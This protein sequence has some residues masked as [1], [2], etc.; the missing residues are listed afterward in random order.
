[1][2]TI[3]FYPDLQIV[4]I[5]SIVLQEYVQKS[6]AQK[7]A[8][9]IKKEGV[10]RHPPIVTASFN[11]SYLHLDGANRITAASL[12]GYS[13]CLV[14][15]VDYSD[16]HQVHLTSWS[17][18]ATM[19]KNQFLRAVKQLSCVMIQEKKAFDHRSP[20]LP[21][22]LAVAVFCDGSAYELRCKTNFADYVKEIGQIVD[23]YA[24]AQVE[25]VF[26]ESPWTPASIRVRFDRFPEHNIFLA[27]PTFSP[28]QVMTLVD[29][30][31]LMPAGLTRHVVYRRKLNINVPLSYLGIASMEEAN[32]KL[33]KFLQKRIVRLYEEPIIY[34][35]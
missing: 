28:Q 12:L 35:E 20:T 30:G 11:G 27:F 21:N 23:L 16:A 8:A 18:V 7:L 22:M 24:D 15:V 9:I 17:H 26:S 31:V 29:R 34:F 14:Q 2:A 25:R 13:S 10:L 19:D 6:R 1:M 5:A 4:P 32:A 33:Q 3:S